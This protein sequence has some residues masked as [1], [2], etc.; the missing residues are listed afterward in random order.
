VV[1]VASTGPYPALAIARAADPRLVAA[2]PTA[3]AL[4]TSLEAG[5][6]LSDAERAG[7]AQRASEPLR[8]HSREELKLRLTEQVLPRLLTDRVAA[9]TEG[10][11]EAAGPM[12]VR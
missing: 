4:A 11:D 12:M 7:Y 5:L 6:A 1:T 10:S 3:E 2:E 9:K 8:A